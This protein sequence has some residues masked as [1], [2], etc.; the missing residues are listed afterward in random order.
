MNIGVQLKTT[1]PITVNHIRSASPLKVLG[2]NKLHKVLSFQIDNPTS[3]IQTPTGKNHPNSKFSFNQTPEEPAE[4]TMK[5]R[6]RLVTYKSYRDLSSHVNELNQVE[7]NEIR[8]R[9]QTMLN[10]ASYV[11]LVKPKLAPIP[12]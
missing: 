8:N 1:N 12:R 9:R 6:K 5:K 2:S 4:T 3:M 10:V 11:P 7:N